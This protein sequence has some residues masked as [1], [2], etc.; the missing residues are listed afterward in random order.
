MRLLA[1][2][3]VEAPV[4]QM[5]RA[6]GHDVVA[7]DEEDPGAE[8]EAVLARATSEGRVLVTNDKDFAELAFLQR[9]A[10]SG[11]LLVRLPRFHSDSK[12]TRSRRWSA[13]RAAASR[14]S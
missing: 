13:S 10:S 5:L 11:I 6:Q 12:A 9:R 3:S 2:E 4:C 8:D 1:D 14:T 7:I